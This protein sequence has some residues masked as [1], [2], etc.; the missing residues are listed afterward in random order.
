MTNVTS[1]SR[2]R[3]PRVGRRL[4]SLRPTSSACTR[5]GRRGR[6]GRPRSST[7]G[8]ARKAACRVVSVQDEKAQLQSRER[9]LRV[10]RA[11][12]YDL[13]LAEQQAAIGAQR[14]SMVGTGGR[15]EKIRTYNGKEN[16]VTD[17]RIKLTLHKR[18]QVMAGDLEELVS[19]LISA[20]RAAQLENPPD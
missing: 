10:L 8:R 2:S 12:L 9:A 7:P 17:H 13:M 20:D 14:R 18:D 19:A 5:G 16:R 15:S 3:G 1:S 11:R 6:A 4:P